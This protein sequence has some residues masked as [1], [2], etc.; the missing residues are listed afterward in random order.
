M[1]TKTNFEDMLCKSAE[2]FSF[3]KKHTD[4]FVL[5]QTNT[6][7]YRQLALSRLHGTS[8][9]SARLALKRLEEQGY[10]QAKSL[11]KHNNEKYYFL[12]TSGRNWIRSA[13]PQEFLEQMAVNWT[14]R[15]PRSPPRRR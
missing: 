7:T 1:I 12:T 6:V 4:L 3:S 9:V 11:D 8:L 15:P 13:F 2:L 10:I 5:L 14:R